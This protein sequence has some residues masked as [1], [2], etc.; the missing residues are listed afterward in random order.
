MTQEDDCTTLPMF[1]RQGPQEPRQAK[2]VKRARAIPPLTAPL[3]TPFGLETM[4]DPGPKSRL[5][6]RMPRIKLCIFL[7]VVHSRLRSSMAGTSTKVGT[8]FGAQCG[9]SR[10][11]IGQTWGEAYD[12]RRDFQQSWPRSANFEPS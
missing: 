11:E 6:S 9:K 3:A 7:F 2:V 1:S 5:E 10:A 8:S 4:G 12:I